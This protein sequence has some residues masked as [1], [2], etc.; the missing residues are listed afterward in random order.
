MSKTTEEKTEEIISHF[1]EPENFW[2]LMWKFLHIFS[3]VNYQF[4]YP[5]SMN[6]LTA[7][8]WELIPCDECAENFP[9]ELVK[10]I[11]DDNRYT[12]PYWA[13]RYFVELHN[14]VNKRLWK[15]DITWE[16]FINNLYDEVNE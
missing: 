15:K 8:I 2:P 5:D 11:Y 7:T 16:E 10:I 4:L 13:A 3:L 14:A 9:K 1:S 12:Y 6:K